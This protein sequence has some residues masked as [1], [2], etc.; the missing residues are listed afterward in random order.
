[1]AH[2]PPRPDSPPPPYSLHPPVLSTG[3]GGQTLDGQGPDVNR[4]GMS[5]IAKVGIGLV[6]IGGAM[7]AGAVLLP[8]IGLTWPVAS[9]LAAAFE[10]VGAVAGVGDGAGAGV[11]A[12]AAALASK[13]RGSRAPEDPEDKEDPGD[14]DDSL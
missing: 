7:T 12:A 1:M 13:I 9:K 10:A 6:A 5:T 4:K 11:I 14:S 2:Q 8:M 3:S